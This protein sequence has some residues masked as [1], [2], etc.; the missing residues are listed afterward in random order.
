M[1]MMFCSLPGQ[2]K[3]VYK[4]NISPKLPS[5]IEQTWIV[6]VMKEADNLKLLLYRRRYLASAYL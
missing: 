1:M 6:L 5:Y 2:E 4:A 3:I